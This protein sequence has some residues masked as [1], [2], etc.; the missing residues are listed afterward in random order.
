M[1]VLDRL[2]GEFSDVRDVLMYCKLL[3]NGFS[4]GLCHH[5]KRFGNVSA[6]LN[7]KHILDMLL[8]RIASGWSNMGFFDLIP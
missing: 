1:K 3:L 5:V 2:G 6:H 8:L 4:F 7:A